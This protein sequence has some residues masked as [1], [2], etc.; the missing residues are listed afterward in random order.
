MANPD[1]AAGALAKPVRGEKLIGSR[2]RRATRTSKEQQVM[3]QALRRDGRQCRV[4][5]CAHRSKRLPIDAC[6]MQHRG[7]GGDPK[8]TRTTLATVLALC[9]AHHGEY[10]AGWLTVAV[11]NHHGA[12]STLDFYDRHGTYLGCSEPRA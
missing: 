5:S 10:D 4:P 2:E 8:G 12:N 7:M 6:H 9:R 11:V 1:L 3:Q